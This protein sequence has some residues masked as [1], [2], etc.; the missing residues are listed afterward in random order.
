MR[1]SNTINGHCLCKKVTIT[2]TPNELH[3]GPCHCESCRRWAS[4]PFF[5]ID[6]KNQV[7]IKGQEWIKTYDSSDW[8]DRG[9]CSECGTNLFYR[10][11]GQNHYMF[12]VG[13]FTEQS[14]FVMDHQVFIDEKPSFY[15]FSEQTKNMTGEECFALFS[16]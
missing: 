3:V 11:K 8:A 7:V 14:D 12:A 5:A 1:T 10:L 6:C 15:S 13:L 2:A 16:E 9:F 4:G